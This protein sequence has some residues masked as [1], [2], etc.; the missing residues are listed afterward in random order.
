MKIVAV[1]LLFLNNPIQYPKMMFC[2]LIYKFMNK[3]MMKL[4]FISTD[5]I[6]DMNKMKFN[7]GWLLIKISHIA[8]RL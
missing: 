8:L 6:P 7:K 3:Y 4:V 1:F 2:T 5:E